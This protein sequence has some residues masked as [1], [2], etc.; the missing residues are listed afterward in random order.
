MTTYRCT[1]I[2]KD[3]LVSVDVV[4]SSKLDNPIADRYTI[5]PRNNVP[6]GYVEPIVCI[7]ETNKGVV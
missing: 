4:F 7:K 2:V 5:Y 6:F 1:M 3:K